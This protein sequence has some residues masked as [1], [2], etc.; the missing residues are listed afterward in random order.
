MQGA[1]AHAGGPLQ[2]SPCRQGKLVPTAINTRESL[3]NAAKSNRL[4]ATIKRVIHGGKAWYA[5]GKPAVVCTTTSPI[6]R[7]RVTAATSVSLLRQTL[8]VLHTDSTPA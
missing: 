8:H 4:P 3:H 7:V 5:V 1:H 2:P 6:E